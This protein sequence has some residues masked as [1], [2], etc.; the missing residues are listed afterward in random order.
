M[1]V[2][3]IVVDDSRIATLTVTD[4]SDS[5]DLLGY[6]PETIQVDFSWT[7]AP[8]DTAIIS[9]TFEARTNQTDAFGSGPINVPGTVT[10]PGT[11]GT[12]AA[13]FI[14]DLSLLTVGRSYFDVIRLSDGDGNTKT[15]VGSVRTIN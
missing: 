14:V 7:A 4:V 8:N 6:G 11:D 3:A 10:N 15:W 9:A 13:T 5:I 2:A 1:K 12:V